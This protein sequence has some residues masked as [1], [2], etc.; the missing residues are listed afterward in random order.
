MAAN[1]SDSLAQINN[2]A[3]N[4]EFPPRIRPEEMEIGKGFPIVD[5]EKVSS[6]FGDCVVTELQFGTETRT[7]F[8]P[9]RMSEG[10]IKQETVIDE[11]RSNKIYSL[12]FKGK[13]EKIS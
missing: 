4:P 8:L 3:S 5:M 7:L 11:I 6:R 2:Y 10:L 1:M 13:V 12:V 9:K